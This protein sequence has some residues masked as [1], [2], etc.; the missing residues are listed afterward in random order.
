MARKGVV[1]VMKERLPQIVSVTTQVAIG[2]E[3]PDSSSSSCIVREQAGDKGGDV[4]RS[5]HGVGMQLGPSL[6]E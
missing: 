6:R 1:K 3:R 4:G 2:G 5:T